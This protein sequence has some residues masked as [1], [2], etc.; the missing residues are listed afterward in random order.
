MF[1]EMIVNSNLADEVLDI[2]EEAY[3]LEYPIEKMK[4]IDE[5]SANDELS[6]SNNNTSCFCYRVI[7]RNF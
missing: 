4:L 6:M 5:Y 2:F 7:E 1:G 3:M